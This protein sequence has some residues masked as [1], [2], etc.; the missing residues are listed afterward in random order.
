MAVAAMKQ[1]YTA[2]F[3]RY[4]ELE[5]NLNARTELSLLNYLKRLKRFRVLVIDDFGL[6]VIRKK[7]AN[8]ILSMLEESFTASSIILTSQLKEDNVGLAIEKSTTR[9]AL[10]DRLICE[11]CDIK[12]ALT[13]TSRRQD[14]SSIKD[15]DVNMSLSF[16]LNS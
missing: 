2:L 1:G 16:N 4:E 15:E 9:D 6:N 14:P 7:I 13:G 12:I 8:K 3:L 5:A 10:I 11:G